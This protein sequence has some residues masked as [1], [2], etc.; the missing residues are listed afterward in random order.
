MFSYRSVLSSAWT[1]T[2]QHKKLWIFGFLAFLLSAGGEYQ[3]LTKILNEEYGAAVYE[4]MLTGNI[5]FTTSF[6]S[7]LIKVCLSE[8]RTGFAVIMMIVLMSALALFIL[9]LC[10]K[11]Q[12]SLVKWTKTYLNSRNKDKKPSIWEEINIKDGNF[13]PVLSLNIAV[14][15]IITAL[16]AIL[17]LPLIFLYFND[18]NLTILVYTIFFI[19]FLPIA[20]SISL[21]VKY[22]I[23]AVVLEK[24]SFVKATEL[25]VKLFIKNWLVSLEM[26]ILLF[27]I[28]F[29]VGLAGVFILSIIIIPIILTLIIFGL[30]TPLYVIAIAAFIAMIIIASALMT[31]Q[32]SSW[33]LLF[34]ELQESGVKA[35]LERIFTKKTKKLRKK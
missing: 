31:F 32:T 24:Q 11:S 33:T 29:L 35:K 1:T 34:I 9:W 7:D 5:F 28:N 14:K 15:I 26:A 23:V 2:K 21:I 25:A 27:L 30:A 18:S 16:F 6:W 12:I 3:V 17:S 20:I 10:V 22:A 19:I 4:K 8:P 13:W